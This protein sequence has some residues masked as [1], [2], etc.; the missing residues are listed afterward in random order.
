MKNAVN[1]LFLLTLAAPLV[2]CA[3]MPPTSAGGGSPQFIAPPAAGDAMQTVGSYSQA[4]VSDASVLA[5][6]NY[7]IKV[8]A[9]R[10]KN[11]PGGES[12][13]LTLMAITGAERQVVAGTNYRLQLRVKQD[14]KERNA[15]VEVYQPL[16]GPDPFSL[17][18]WTWAT[19]A[20]EPAQPQR[21]PVAGGYSPMPV[22]DPVVVAGAD[23][24]V[25]GETYYLQHQPGGAAAQL[26]LVSITGAEQQVVAGMNY[27]LQLRV[28]HDGKERDAEAVLYR[29]LSGNPMT[30]TSWTWK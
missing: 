9:Y 18:N 27:R 24:A 4:P 26:T 19:T 12:S 22:S 6:A 1:F 17:K 20:S 13:Q 25:Q 14:G 3:D 23:I 29:P 21:L 2:A 5:A 28:R 10:L 30:L 11:Q 16:G 15:V 7:A 8:Q